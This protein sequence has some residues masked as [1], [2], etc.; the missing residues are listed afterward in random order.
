[1][2]ALLFLLVLLSIPFEVLA[3]DTV[4]VCTYNV[5]K[6]SASNE[7]GRIPQFATILNE[8]R[9]DVLLCQEVDDATMGPRF[10]NDVLTWAPFAASAFLDG[11]DTDVQMFYNQNTFDFISQSRIK[12]ELRDI[13]E[14]ILATRPTNGLEPDTVVVYTMHLKASRG[15]EQR[16][17]DEIDSLLKY[18]L[19]HQNVIVAGDFNIY[20]NQ[21]PAYTK[22]LGVPFTDPIGTTWRR[23]L[24]AFASIYTQCTRQNQDGACGGGVSGGID[25]RFDLI[26]VSEALSSRIVP[27]T[28]LAFGN[29]GVP[30]LNSSINDPKN[31]LVSSEVADALYCASDHLPVSVDVVLGDVQASVKSFTAPQFSVLFVGNTLEVSGCRL[32]TALMVHDVRGTLLY[33]A[34]VTKTEMR[35]DASAFPNG[36]YFVSQLNAAVGISIVR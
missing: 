3:A 25:D 22:L 29:D 34:R 11:N 9:P 18:M 8:I 33:T 24:P 1:M 35:I 10:V 28:Y 14:F 27:E 5:L 16:R 20:T 6:Y 7:D 15:S 12:T 26:M 19:D 4:R 21:E 23:D 13:G 36:F 31:T 30:R 32:G 17:A 2:K